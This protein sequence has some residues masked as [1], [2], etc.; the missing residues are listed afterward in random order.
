[1]ARAGL[2]FL[3]LSPKPLRSVCISLIGAGDLVVAVG[4]L[5]SGFAAGASFF[6]SCLETAFGV[7]GFGVFLCSFHLKRSEWRLDFFCASGFSSEGSSGNK[8]MDVSPISNEQI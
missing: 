8:K 5:A 1:M 2:S 3:T 4:F 6:D 7:S